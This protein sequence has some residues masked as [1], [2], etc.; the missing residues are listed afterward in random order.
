MSLEDIVAIFQAYGEVKFVAIEKNTYV[1]SFAGTDAVQK[2]C[3]K[4]DFE[5][6]GTPVC[7]RPMLPKPLPRHTLK[8][9]MSQLRVSP[10]APVSI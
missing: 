9:Q 2:A 4:G 7:V 1:I 3:A 8:D 10:E 6:A 5:F